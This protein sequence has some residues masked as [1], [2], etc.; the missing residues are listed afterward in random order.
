L[1]H[2]GNVLAFSVGLSILIAFG[3]AMLVVSK[4][5]GMLPPG[6]ILALGICIQWVGV[7]FRQFAYYLGGGYQDGALSVSFPVWLVG[8]WFTITGGLTILTAIGQEDEQHTFPTR[9]FS[10]LGIIIGVV[11]ALVMMMML[12]VTK[13]HVDKGV[14]VTKFP[15]WCSDCHKFPRE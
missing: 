3:R 9:S 6:H 12:V 5:E 11:A 1:F 13:L 2:V 15:Q 7:M 4:T 14:S 8:L 10:I